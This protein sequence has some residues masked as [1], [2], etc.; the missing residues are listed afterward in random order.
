MGIGRRNHEP[1]EQM[2]SVHGRGRIKSQY[3]D[4]PTMLCPAM[5]CQSSERA[6]ASANFPVIQEEEGVQALFSPYAMSTLSRG[7][8]DALLQPRLEVVIG[9]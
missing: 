2:I 5:Y 1:N 3:L 6:S 8:L 7:S 9:A 4:Y